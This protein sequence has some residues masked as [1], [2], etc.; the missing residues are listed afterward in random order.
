MKPDSRVIAVASAGGTPR[1]DRIAAS[2]CSRAESSSA[3]ASGTT[4]TWIREM[5]V[6][7]T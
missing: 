7:T 3:I 2:G 5:T 4:T 6:S 1:L